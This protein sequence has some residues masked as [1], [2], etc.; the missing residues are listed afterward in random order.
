MEEKEADQGGGGSEAAVVWWAFYNTLVM[1]YSSWRVVGGV[2]R[3]GGGWSVCGLLSSPDA[4]STRPRHFWPPAANIVASN[5]RNQTR[6]L[7]SFRILLLPYQTLLLLHQTP[8]LPSH[9]SRLN[10]ASTCRPPNLHTHMR[11]SLCPSNLPGAK[12]PT[13]AN[14]Y[15]QPSGGPIRDEGECRAFRVMYGKLSKRKHK[16]W[17]DDG[18]L[19]I[20]GHRATLRSMDDRQLSTSDDFAAAKVNGLGEDSVLV[21]GSLEVY[22][23]EKIPWADYQN[24]K[25]FE[26][27]SVEAPLP[28][29]RLNPT[30]SK[31]YK[32]PLKDTFRNCAANLRIAQQAKKPLYNPDSEGALV[33]PQPD[34]QHQRLYNP[35]RLPINT[36]MV[37]P[38]LGRCLRPHQRDGVEFLYAALVDLRSKGLRGAILG[39]EMGLG[40]TLQTIAVIWTLLKQAP[41]GHQPLLKKVL[42]VC[43]STLVSNWRAE[44]KK[45]LGDDRLKVF[46]LAESKEVIEFGRTSALNPVLILSYEVMARAMEQ[47][48]AQK[49][50]LLVCDE[51][52]RVKN[53]DSKTYQALWGLGISRRL[54]ITGTPVQNDLRELHALMD[55]VC[56]GLLGELKQFKRIYEAPIMAGRRAAASADAKETG[57]A[58]NETLQE[59]LRPHFLRRTAEV[60][61]SYLKPRHDLVLFCRPSQLQANLYTQVGRS[62]LAQIANIISGAGITTKHLTAIDTLRKLCNH[63]ALLHQA[64]KSREESEE[65]DTDQEALLTHFPRDYEDRDFVV[66]ESGKLSVLLVLLEYIRRECPEEKVVLVS[67]YRRTLTLVQGVCEALGYRMLRLDG[68]TSKAQREEAVNAFNRPSNDTFLFL[69]SLKAGGVGLNLI[70]ASRLI[71]FETDWNPAL[72]R[73]AMARIW[74]DGQQR[75][76][77]IYRLVTT[78]SLEERQLQ[79]Q[80]SKTSLSD[81]VV[82]KLGSSGPRLS[83]EEM[84]DLFR[85]HSDTDSLVHRNAACH[86]DLRGGRAPGG[87]DQVLSSWRHFQP[88]MLQEATFGDSLPFPLPDSVSLVFSKTTEKED[89]NSMLRKEEEEAKATSVACNFQPDGTP[90]EPQEIISETEDECLSLS[91]KESDKESN[92][93]DAPSWDPANDLRLID[94]VAAD[95]DEKT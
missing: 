21:V 31:P 86:C 27:N 62:L 90:D 82:D 72:D 3:V 41:Y 32:C 13:T 88:R 84:R 7:S 57:D 25:V 80:L 23:L 11:R 50:D 56:P 52:H 15:P 38:R 6:T 17:D 93:S 63:P 36:L 30:F 19:I 74:R 66:E 54:L 46:A 92:T 85:L 78:G 83:P 75:P 51:G 22:I 26:K 14:T 44:F 77:H 89:L 29:P 42:I 60:N 69:L 45:W 71:L 64:L 5:S 79:R 58:R 16:K 48:A 81:Q 61:Q 94:E 87:A 39:D 43:P 53:A 47:L 8:L 1:S 70:G 49:F 10:S 33:L 18:V 76:C 68:E 34:E 24:G 67:S 59:L 65:L 9:H 91:D 35:D 4:H 12:R 20:Q 73:Q 28:S 40:K 95:E 55:F 2:G 37:D